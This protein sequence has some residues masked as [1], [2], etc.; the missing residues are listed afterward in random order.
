MSISDAATNETELTLY[1]SASSTPS[2]NSEANI[3]PAL[4][5]LRP[6]RAQ[7]QQQQQHHTNSA[8]LLLCSSASIAA[9]TADHGDEK[10]EEETQRLHYPQKWVPNRH[11]RGGKLLRCISNFS[12]S[13]PAHIVATVLCVWYLVATCVTVMVIWRES[14]RYALLQGNISKLQQRV[15]MVER[16]IITVSI[17]AAAAAASASSSSNNTAAATD[18]NRTRGR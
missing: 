5:E 9:E 3:T 7:Q 15:G 4:D 16:S 18:N 8:L 14:E 12:S 11:Q 1:V 10:E 17:P 13:C 2:C 6:L